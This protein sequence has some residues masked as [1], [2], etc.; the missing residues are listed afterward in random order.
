MMKKVKQL[1]LFLDNKPGVLSRVCAVLARR[2]V[3]LL[4]LSVSDGHDHAVVRM[5]ADDPRRA[6]H[7]LGEAGILVVEND[8]LLMTF[9]N[10]TGALGAVA[11]A[12]ARAGVNIEYSYC[13]SP[14]DQSAAALVLSVSDIEAAGR[15]L[16]NFS[17]SG[18]RKAA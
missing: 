11:R 1:S 3:N 2:K 5:V 18:K 15:V 9:P 13:T 17:S 8:V 7:C 10:R 12:L 14:P 6:I 16:K 4:G